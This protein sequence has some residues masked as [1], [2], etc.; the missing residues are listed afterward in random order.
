MNLCRFILRHWLAC[1]ALV[2]LVVVGGVRAE[3]TLI[4][5][6]PVAGGAEVVL[7]RTAD[8][9]AG[10][11]R[12]GGNYCLRYRHPNGGAREV[13]RMQALDNPDQQICLGE[14]RVSLR[15]FTRYDN[16]IVTLDV[17]AEEPRLYEDV[18]PSTYGLDPGIGLKLLTADEL[19][20][21]DDR[22]PVCREKHLLRDESGRWTFQGLPYRKDLH[23]KLTV[24][25]PDYQQLRV[26]ELPIRFGWTVGVQ[27]SYPITAMPGLYQRLQD[28]HAVFSNLVSWSAPSATVADEEE[29]LLAQ[30]DA[31]A[32]PRVDT[33]LTGLAPPYFRYDWPWVRSVFFSKVRF[34]DWEL[35]L[36]CRVTEYDDAVAELREAYLLY[37]IYSTELLAQSA[38]SFDELAFSALIVHE[39]EKAGF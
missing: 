32:W 37:E 24:F 29:L 34:T 9:G 23:T 39:L 18:F 17:N 10:G 19:V 14:R 11:I 7:V 33:A 38:Q 16:I 13:Y 8:P 12:S 6:W 35:K 36:P 30:L 27:S 21:R 4:K 20:L 1:H 31:M 22:D 2:W 26:M 5:R 25:S 3:D 15:F 28:V